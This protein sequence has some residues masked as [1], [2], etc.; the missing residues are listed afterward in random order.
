MSGQ[1]QPQPNGRSQGWVVDASVGIQLF[2]DGPRSNAAHALFEH[3][4]AEPPANLYVP[5]LFYIEIANVLWKYVRWH[6]LDIALAQE[7]LHQ[8]DQLFLHRVPTSD[9][10]VDALTQAATYN[11]TAYDACYVALAQRVNVP[12]ITADE[13]LVK[14]INDSARVQLLNA[15]SR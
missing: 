1:P 6:G 10:M 7:Y 3:L 9:L 4:T 2:I 14:A 8:L 5:D 15:T 12:L 11:I 13:K